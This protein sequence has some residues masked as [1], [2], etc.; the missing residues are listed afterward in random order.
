VKKLAII[1]ILL[2]TPA[3]AE[4]A[5]V[6]KPAE[7]PA[8]VVPSPPIPVP[9]PPTEWFIRLDQGMINSIASCAQEMKKRDADPFLFAIDAQLKGQPSIIAAIKAK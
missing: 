7:T 1:A 9:L 5:P 6:E 2:A 4:D 3:F 8:A